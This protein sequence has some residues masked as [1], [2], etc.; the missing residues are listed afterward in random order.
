MSGRRNTPQVRGRNHGLRGV[1]VSS[2]FRPC[3]DGTRPSVGHRA[4]PSVGVPAN[5]SRAPGHTAGATNTIHSQ[6]GEARLMRRCAYTRCPQLIPNGERYCSEH[7]RARDNERGSSAQ[8]GYGSA[9]QQER[10]QWWQRLADGE[11]VTCPRCGRPI[12]PGQCWDLGHN[13]KRDA[14][15]GPEHAHCNRAAGAANSQRM[16]EHWTKQ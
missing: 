11:Q 12:L 13:D 16:R 6:T 9:H 7:K 2:W 4:G 8:R 1:R 10:A 5:R 15:T 14:W 3:V